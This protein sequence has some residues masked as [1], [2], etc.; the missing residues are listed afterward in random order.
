MFLDVQRPKPV[1]A[2]GDVYVSF[3]ALAKL[4]PLTLLQCLDLHQAAEV[5]DFVWSPALYGKELRSTHAVCDP[6]LVI[7]TLADR[8][9]T[10][11]IIIDEECAST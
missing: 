3:A 9:R 7:I 2:L 11:L 5:Q 4:S 10:R 6:P 8:S 1:F